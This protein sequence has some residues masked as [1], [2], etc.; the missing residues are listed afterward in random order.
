MS[1]IPD[2]PHDCARDG[3]ASNESPSNRQ[4][5]RRF[6]QVISANIE[7]LYRKCRKKH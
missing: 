6:K 7:Y 3:V 5:Q 2:N 1:F 4:K